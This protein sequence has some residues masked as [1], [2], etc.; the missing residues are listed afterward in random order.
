MLAQHT[1]CCCRRPSVGQTIGAAGDSPLFLTSIGR[2]YTQLSPPPQKN[3]NELSVPS[4]RHY[5]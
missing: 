3:E 5:A 2:I 4:D 1:T